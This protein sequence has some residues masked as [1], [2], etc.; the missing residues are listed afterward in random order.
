MS[1]NLWQYRHLIKRLAIS[2]FKVRYK[3]SVLGFFWSLLEP[4]L[5]L[6]VLYVVFVDVFPSTQ[7][8]YHL[9][10]LLGIALWDF[11]TKGTSMGLQAIISK[12]GMVRQV[13]I[14]REILIFSSSLTALMMA[15]LEIG[16][17]GIFMVISGV[18]PTS[19]AIYF[20]I[21]FMIIFILVFGTSLALGALNTYYRDVQ[22]IWA[23]ILQ[24]GF[25]ASGVFFD[26]STYE[27]DIKGLLLLNPMARII[28]ISRE[29]LLYNTAVSSW[30]L[31][32]C[33]ASS[34]VMLLV[35]YLIFMKLEPGFAEE[36]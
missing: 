4:L 14:P 2:D 15:V 1:N 30:D 7:K 25:F 21:I 8:N 28:L 32:F 11:F 5:M 24:A 19:T 22:Y 20:P 27:S 6:L 33:F 31:V 18:M 29:S 17:F 35:G 23:V 10:L 12:P 13:Y 3:N 34:L 16:V 9:F 36:V 26:F